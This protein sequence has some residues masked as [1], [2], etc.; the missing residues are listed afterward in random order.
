ME[1]FVKMDER[2]DQILVGENKYKIEH[3]GSKF[4]GE[5]PDNLDT[6]IQNLK[7]YTLEDFSKYENLEKIGNPKKKGFMFWGNFKEYSAAFRIYVYDSKLT[8]RIKKLFKESK[9]RGEYETL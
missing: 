8:N 6:F 5:E 2:F 7:K 3:N 1:T 4:A 9:N